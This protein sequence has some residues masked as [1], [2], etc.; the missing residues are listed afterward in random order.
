MIMREPLRMIR[1]PLLECIIH[2]KSERGKRGA[3]REGR[4]RQALEESRQSGVSLAKYGYL[5][6]STPTIGDR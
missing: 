2:A 1:G 5:G 3:P 6:Q 4:T